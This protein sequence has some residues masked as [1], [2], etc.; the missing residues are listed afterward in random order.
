M[1][2]FFKKFCNAISNRAWRSKRTKNARYRAEDFLKVFFY[3]EVADRSIYDANEMLNALYL[4]RRKGLRK[5]YI[6]E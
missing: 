6:N 5:T 1:L 3:S 2:A 4:S